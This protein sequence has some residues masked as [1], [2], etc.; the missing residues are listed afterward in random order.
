MK[1]YIITWRGCPCKADGRVMNWD[2]PEVE[3]QTWIYLTEQDAIGVMESDW[4]KEQW[5]EMPS[6][7]WA[8]LG[9]E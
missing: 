5:G 6:Q 4:W 9:L 1:F 3:D 2:E 8:V 7:Y